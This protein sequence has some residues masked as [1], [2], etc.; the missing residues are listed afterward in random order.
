MEGKKK[1]APTKTNK[2]KIDPAARAAAISKARDAVTRRREEEQE[3]AAHPVEQVEASAQ[4]AAYEAGHAIREA[5]HTIRTCGSI[6]SRRETT[7]ETRAFTPYKPSAPQEGARVKAASD[8][9]KAAQQEPV[10]PVVEYPDFDP[11]A[12][13]SSI[14]YAPPKPAPTTTHTPDASPTL[15]HEHG[16]SDIKTPPTKAPRHTASPTRSQPQEAA[17]LHAIAEFKHDLQ[18]KQQTSALYPSVH[19]SIHP[20]EAHD[21]LPAPIDPP[22]LFHEKP[23]QEIKTPPPIAAAKPTDTTPPGQ[24]TG[25]Q[26]LIQ[27]AKSN[28][29]KHAA[30]KAADSAAPPIAP[31]TITPYTETKA[32]KPL[33]RLQTAVSPHTDP[34]PAIPT[35]G[36]TI[37]TRRRAEPAMKLKSDTRAA[38]IKTKNVTALPQLPAAPGVIK[39]PTAVN[40]AEQTEAKRNA[41]RIRRQ[42]KELAIKQLTTPDKRISKR[43]ILAV[44]KF[45]KAA[46]KAVKDLLSALA[47]YC[48]GTVLI[49]IL[50]AV[51]LVGALVSSPMG[52]LFSDEA[53]GDDG[54]SLTSAIGQISS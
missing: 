9:A 36:I 49:I 30:S 47:S 3:N 18:T 27:K 19:P 5:A 26:A 31:V 2:S 46:G 13:L 53:S 11:Y 41:L 33:N 54:V 12:G 32:T 38:A 8:A 22:A 50:C 15:L 4:Y 52:I 45:A 24:Q 25:R 35:D 43:L 20:S 51:L 1:Q 23:T 21:Q 39:T 6:Q 7:D 29:S 14:P 16:A 44:G 34:A 42:G 40:A 17:R 37:K 10:I 48:G 28:A